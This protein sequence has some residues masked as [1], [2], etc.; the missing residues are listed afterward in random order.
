MTPHR[1][2]TSLNTVGIAAARASLADQA[3]AAR[4][5]ARN[6]KIRSDFVTFLERRSYEP[7][8]SSANFLMV[9]IRRPV[10]P[11]IDALRQRGFLV[12]RLFPSMPTHLRISLGT[13]K[14]MARF[15]PVLDE[16]LRA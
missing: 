1:L 12:G 6:A 5:R 15:E 4:V 7:I 16:V 14:Q 9:D 11:T 2:Q 3:S 13:E 10:L 8:P